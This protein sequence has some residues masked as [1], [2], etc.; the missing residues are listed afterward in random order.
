M[1]NELISI[2][3]P[4]YNVENYLR[5][6]LDSIS[7]QTYKNFECILVNDGS[8]D[9]SQQIAEEY[10][11]DSRFKLINQSNK[12]LSG[13]RNTGISHI[14]EESTFISFVDSDDYIYPDFLETLIEHI[15]DDVDIIEGMIEYFNDEIKVDNVFHNF[16]K[17]ILTTKDDKLRKLTL[18]ELRVSV[19][20]KLFRKS[21]LTEDFFPEGWI[22]EDLAVVPE[23]VSHSRKWIKLP[24]VIYG[25]RIRPNSITTKEFSEEKLDVFK[26]FEKYDLFFENENDV[27]KLLVEKLKYLH[28]N[29]HDIE[30]LPENNQYKQLYQQEKQK[31]LSKIADYESKALISII[32]PIYNV[33]KYLRQCLDSIQDQTYQN[34]EC[35]LINDGSSDNSA[36]ICREYVSKDSRFRYIEKENGGV[37]SARNLGIEHSKGE[38]ITFID[39]DD[40]VDSDYL[41]VLYTALIDE[42]ADI[43]VSTY[44]RFH[45][46]DNCW[47]V[48]SFQRGYEKRVF[49]N[50]ELIDEFIDLDTFDYSYRYVCGKLVRKCLLD[51]IAFNEMTTLGEDMEF[52]LKLYLISNKV[53][54]VN[55][56]SYIYRLDNVDRHFGLEKICSDIQ[57]RLNF[58]AFLA[59]RGV[60]VSKYVKTCLSLITS[61]VARLKE[62]PEYDTYE[63]IRWLHEVMFLLEGRSES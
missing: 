41:E 43:S 50:Q 9:S 48:H 18:N 7:E 52:W 51:K 58:I 13:A 17:Q 45:M 35:L 38:Y 30:F 60:N 39:S 40:W 63:T 5:Q 33:E 4:I 20:P 25:Y 32:V 8:T 24:K 1:E 15:E 49:T 3:V 55:R 46:A 14:R 28:L 2:V 62:S 29:Y 34:F 22:F 27:T 26:I 56:D 47:Y 16:E 54:F 53:V 57:Q 21:L 36:D 31:L 59:V 23:L 10:L 12:G 6:C 37:S 44:K 19:F 61:Q 11:V 42:N